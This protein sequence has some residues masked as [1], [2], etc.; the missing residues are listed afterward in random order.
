LNFSQLQSSVEMTHS[1][2]H[3]LGSNDVFFDGWNESYVV[4][5]AMWNNSET[6]F[7]G[8]TTG[9]VRLDCERVALM[10]AA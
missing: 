1:N 3:S 9:K 10:F 4:Q 6:Q 7:F 8:I 5:S 2:V